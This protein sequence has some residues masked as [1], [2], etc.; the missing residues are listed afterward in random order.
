MGLKIEISSN[1]SKFGFVESKKNGLKHAGDAKDGHSFS[2]QTQAV[3][4]KVKK[5]KN[6]KQ[7]SFRNKNNFISFHSVL[8]SIYFESNNCTTAIKFNP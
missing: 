7:C 6:L 2:F 5:A 3:P 8:L 4:N 1:P